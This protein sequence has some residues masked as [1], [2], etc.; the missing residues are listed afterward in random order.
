V[1]LRCLGAVASDLENWP[2]A[3]E[4]FEESL[5]RLEQIEARHEQATTHLLLAM[6][7]K[8][9]AGTGRPTDTTSAPLEESLRHALKAHSI[10]QELKLSHCLSEVDDLISS[11][12]WK[13]VGTAPGGE[14]VAMNGG[15]KQ[16]CMLPD[17]RRPSAPEVIGV[18]A[19]MR[20]VLQQCATF[21]S[22]DEPVLVTGET[23]TGKD[24]LARRIHDQSPRRDKPFVAVN[25]AA[26]PATLFERE[27]FGNRKGAYSSADAD[28]PG[29]VAQAEGGTL[30]L[31][32][33]G[34]MPWELQAK[35]LR[36]LQDGTY[37]RLGDPTER[38]GDIRLI[39][40]TNAD[41]EELAAE[42]RFRQDLLYR[43]R[44]LELFLAPLRDRPEDI[45]PLL[46]HFL[47]Q[48]AGHTT[49]VWSYFNEASVRA[50]RRY[51]WTGNVREVQLIARRAHIDLQS[52]GKVRIELGR[53]AGAVLLTG[54]AAACEANADV[55]R[56]RILNLL[57]E[58]G[59][60][61]AETA[62]LLGVARQTLYR[63]LER[64]E[65]NV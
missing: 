22:F 35:L 40:A 57:E 7:I 29:F 17:S 44:T 39:A 1:T 46:N 24:L 18:S 25:C 63:W 28:V 32:E 49:T 33:V 50:L 48:C 41:L 11:L 9:Q 37:T 31:D 27:F 47:S 64:Y 52:K 14:P 21:A 59:G 34:E 43:I 36:L 58:T 61:K 19:Q 2:Q 26:I 54:P 4:Y 55:T 60:N 16:V 56:D 23:G 6:A 10:F 62:R 38:Y 51:V 3:R 12:A 42:G 5:S 53:G 20:A 15:Q 65:I 8:E 13:H 45:L 30:F